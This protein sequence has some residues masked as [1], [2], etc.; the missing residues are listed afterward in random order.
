MLSKRIALGVAGLCFLL[1]VFAGGRNPLPEVKYDQYRLSNGLTVI[2]VEDHSVPIVGVNVNYQVGSK[3]ETPGHTGFAHLF[4]H[5]MFQGSKN[6]NDDYFKPLQ[7]VGAFVNG[8]TNTDR[9]RY[10]ET[11]PSAYLERALWMEADRMGFL[12]DALTQERL[13]NQISVVQ[14]ERRQRYENSPYGTVYE[15]MMAVLYP[16]NHP[17]HWTTIGS[18]A[19]LQ[20]ASLEDVRE[21]FKTYYAPN[22][23]SLCIVGDFAPAKTKK[24]V[25]K[26]FG[27]IPPGPPVS[28][29]GTWVPE[30]PGE[31]T[32]DI[33]DRVRL[34]RTYV[35]WHTSPWYS[36]DDAAMDVF[37]SILGGGRTSR[38]YK[39]LV[40]D[41]QIA[42]EAYAYNDA[43]Q[44]AGHFQMVLTPRPGHTLS[45][46]ENAAFEVLNDSLKNG[47]TQ[48]ELD[49]EVT[50]RT[51]RYVRSMQSVG[52]FSSLSDRMNG[53]YHYLGK[54]DYFRQ[55]LQ[56]YIDLTPETV[57]AAARHYLNGNRL[58]ARVHPAGKT[59]PSTSDAAVKLDRSV[60]PG[61]GEQ[62]AFKL[63]RRQRFTLSN[64]LDVVLVEQHEVPLVEFRMLVRG[65][66]SVDPADRHGL[67]SLTASMLREGAAGMSSQDIDEAVE[68][69]GARLHVGADFDAVEA[70]LS[71]LRTNLDPSLELFSNVLVHPDFPAAELDRIKKTRLVGFQ[72]AK[73]Q[74]RELGQV[75]FLKVLYGERAYGHPP[76]GTEN[77]VGATAIDD[78]KGYW[79]RYGVPSNATLVVAGD[80]TRGDIEPRLEK[81]FGGWKGGEA[82]RIDLPGVKQHGSRTIYLVNKK[83]AAQSFIMCGHLGVPRNAADYPA[84]RLVNDVLG[85][86][87]SAR[88]FMN[89]RED[90]GYTYGAYSTFR[91]RRS[92]GP[93]LAYAS[94][95]TNVTAPAVKEFVGEIRGIAGDR[96]VSEK[97]LD[98]S[99]G[100][101]TNNYAQDFETPGQ[102][103]GRVADAI[104]YGLPSDALETLPARIQALTLEQARAAAA[105]Y[106]LPDHLAIVVVGD[107]D[108][109]KPELEK[110]NLGP[111]VELDEN[112][113][114]VS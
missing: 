63:P 87:A 70:G 83:G 62:S 12:L 6:Y 20:A 71:A 96:P 33:Q 85:G 60:M 89:L 5:M 54:P 19:D 18:M 69:L 23:A 104:L 81:A 39:K 41:M 10:L 47:I 42:Q 27:A 30:L 57:N 72:Q 32:L 84:I 3:N 98:F 28:R 13:S 55:D 49:R 15:K 59:A 43:S 112:G 58:I 24:M 56:R 86:D 9:T 46:V 29:L 44:I 37:G 8:G 113:D 74:P 101:L 80:V 111:V 73:D 45:E 66:S 77:G 48:K 64:G 100:G 40:Y 52:G 35:A 67:A 53:Y 2:L 94:V 7:S 68:G 50:S 22:N 103:A 78:V 91:F 97:E 16:P 4:E 99:R 14:N 25:E 65:G 114:R 82:P 79:A 107:R 38:L 17:Y 90:K 106:I 75:A 110:L 95:A 36:Q 108:S 51:A 11:V 102:V 61:R 88:L 105:K 109:V 21:F 93:F 76:E 92:S 34:P 31:V 1:N 26:Y